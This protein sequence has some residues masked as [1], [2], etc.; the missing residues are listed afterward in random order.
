MIERKEKYINPFTD[1]GSLNA[2][3]DI[4]NSVD[5]AEEKAVLKVVENMIGMGMTNEAIQR[6]T[7]L[8][9]DRIEELRKNNR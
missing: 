2:Y 7:E 5:W 6:A 9:L 3:R 4:K 8:S 1:Y